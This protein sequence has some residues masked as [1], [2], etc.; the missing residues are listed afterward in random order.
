MSKRLYIL[1][2]WAYETSKWQPF[3]EQ[4]R[5]ADFELELLQIP[6]LTTEPL[7]AAWT[8]ED[9]VNWLDGIVGKGPAII[10]GHSNG[11]RIAL[12]YAV[13]F[14]AKVE[15]LILIDSAGIPP[16][17]LKSTVKRSIL[18]GMAKTGKL[19]TKSPKARQ[20]LYKVAR[21]GDYFQASEVMRQTMANLLASDKH[22]QVQNVSVPT[23]L[24]WGS[25][26]TATP[27]KDGVTMQ[28]KLPKASLNII[29][30][31]RHSPQFT[32]PEKVVEIIK[33]ALRS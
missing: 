4:L 14:P 21:E 28:K 11:G 25:A 17:G 12:N 33:E 8:I 24:I 6:G 29:D 19:L 26:D 2:G 7:L 10:M 15:R 32:H 5:A 31:A 20:L 13:R 23:T 30:E 3:M 9:Y 18:K 22:L 1:H 27:L 16:T